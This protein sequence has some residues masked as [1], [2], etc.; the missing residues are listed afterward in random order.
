MAV[1]TRA[2]DD[3]VMATTNETLQ[4]EI[5]KM[6]SDI[7]TSMDAMEKGFA[8][9]IKLAELDVK[10][11]ALEARVTALEDRPEVPASGARS[12]NCVSYEMSE[13]DGKNVVDMVNTL[14][15]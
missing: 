10:S 9:K 5:R 3:D 1:R 14:V 6:S 2:N 12:L 4:Q 13:S 8:A 7:G 11:R 15:A